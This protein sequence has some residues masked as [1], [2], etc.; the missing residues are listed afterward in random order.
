MR[1]TALIWCLI[2]CA[3][4]MAQEE[5]AAREIRV[6]ERDVF[7]VASTPERVV[8][9]EP[10]G[11]VAAVAPRGEPRYVM[12][13]Q[14]VP[15]PEIGGKLVTLEEM[16]RQVESDAADFTDVAV[17]KEIKCRSVKYGGRTGCYATLTD[18]RLVD[19][20]NPPVNDFKHVAVGVIR[21]SEETVLQFRILTNDLASRDFFGPLE[22]AMSLVKPVAGATTRNAK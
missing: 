12:R 4:V 1:W 6:G 20:A 7:R 5:L 21:L 2:A 11:L 10:G 3:S 13:L 22:Y 18:G 19:V 9:V 15:D 8:Q 14:F 16:K 17:E